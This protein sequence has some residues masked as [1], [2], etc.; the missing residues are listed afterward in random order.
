MHA[1]RALPALLANVSPF[2][3][4]PQLVVAALRALTDIANAAALASS[5]SPLCIETLADNVFSAQNLDSFGAMLSFSSADPLRQSQVTLTAGLISRLCKEDRHQHALTSGGILDALSTRLA[6]FAV[7]RGQVIPGADLAARKDGLFG[8]FPE[9]ALQGAQ[10]TPVLEAIAAILGDSKYRAY[11]LV[12]SPSILAVFPSIKFDPAI[13]LSGSIPDLDYNGHSNFRDSR[14]PVTAMEYLLPSAVPVNQSRTPYQSQSGGLQQSGLSQSSSRTS[15]NKMSSST[16]WDSPRFKT[17]GS[18]VE[19]DSEGVESPLIPWL[20]HLVRSSEKYD[21]L[22]ASEILASLMKAG[23]G[24]KG[25]RET[26]LGLLVIPPLVDMISKNDQET[27]SEKAISNIDKGQ[28]SLRRTIVERGPVILARLIMDSEYLQKA[29]F[30]CSAVKVLSKLLKHAYQ[31]IDET[32]QPR[33]WSP[34][35]DTGM[36]VDNGTPS[37]QL[38]EPGQNSLLLHRLSVRESTLKAIAA[39][40]GGKEDYRKAFLAD[41]ILPYIVE[42]LSEYPRKPRT[43]K[44]RTADKSNDDGTRERATEGYGTN[45]AIVIIAGCHVV[46][47]L[48][49]SV[50]I[51][52][53]ALVD[54]GVALPILKFMKHPDTNV[55]IAATAAMAN[56]VIEVSP[57]REVSGHQMLYPTLLCTDI[58]QML[59]EHGV[60]KVLCA[61][62]HSDNA[63]L[64]LNA[65][66]ALKHF[67]D[68]VGPD[69]KKACLQELEAEWLMQLICEDKE[70]AALQMAKQ[71]EASGLDMDDDVDMQSTDERHRWVYGSNGVL[72]EL[73]ASQSTRLRQAEDKLLAVRESELNPVRRARNDDTAIQEQGLDFIRNYIGRPGASG[74][75][76]DSANETVE[77]IDHLFNELGQDRLFDVL[78]SKLRPKVLRSFSRRAPVAG[79]ETRVAHPQAKVIV[80][81]IYIL[82]HLAASIPRYR[83]LVISQT[84]LL[85]LLAQQFGSKD[86]E[87]R[88]ALCHLIINLTWQDDETEAPACAQRAQELKKLGYHTKMENLKHQD[89]DLDVRE[90]AKTAAWQIQQASY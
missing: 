68:A 64:R 19:V 76:V 63:A 6:S 81:V 51:L 49:R 60:M 41:D 57:V 32:A 74:L 80:V 40:A 16:G 70:D 61:H 69:L 66:W 77:M 28:D 65:L 13:E 79:R 30:D 8:A 84:D 44:E 43:V 39:L 48:S 36:D 82:V 20:V 21:R 42:S 11:R 52:R 33:H 54:F 35:P 12:N 2:T 15:L 38:G 10:I 37:A 88:I 31:P 71:R 18:G 29:A 34:L 72:Q 55:Q 17:S 23:L 22:L 1:A 87:V 7:A 83:Q 59:T 78:A 47:M 5:S 3:N 26:S 4:A 56:L 14:Q 73:D 90:R 85:K 27:N 45:P 86:K 75:A 50:N 89:V 9:P 62:A 46:R 25:L 53:T 58:R 67:V 24:S